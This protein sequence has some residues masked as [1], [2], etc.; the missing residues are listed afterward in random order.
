MHMEAVRG[1]DHSYLAL[2]LHAVFFERLPEQLLRDFAHIRSR[3][4]TGKHDMLRNFDILQ[5][6]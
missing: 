3:E 6:K 2:A 4:A 5:L 1:T